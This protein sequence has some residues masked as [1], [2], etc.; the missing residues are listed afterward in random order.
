MPSVYADTSFLQFKKVHCRNCYKCVRNCPVKAIRVINHQAQILE[1]QCILCEKC[2]LVCPQN[3]KEELNMIPRVHDFIQSGGQ[4]IA[5][6]HPAYVAEFGTD[7]LPALTEALKKLGLSDAFDAAAGAYL[8]KTA[9]E[10]LVEERAQVT[11]TISS[12]CPVI[13]QL[14][15]KR[16]PDLVPYLAPVLSVMQAHARYLKEQYPDA[17]ILSVSPCISGLAQMREADNYVDYVITFSELQEWLTA[18]QVQVAA[19]SSAPPD[20]DRDIRLS[21]I[22][23]MSGGF[24]MAMHPSVHQ[25]YLPACGI[26][27]CKQILTEF[28]A[29]PDSYSNCFL[30]LNACPNGCI[31]GPSFRRTKTGLLHG[32]IR[33][34]NASL[35]KGISNYKRDD[36]SAQSLTDVSRHYDTFVLR[37]QEAEASEEDIKKVL[38]QMGKFTPEDELNCGACGYNTCREKAKAV[39]AGKAEISMC[40]PFM[41]ERQESYSNK[42]IN[43]MPGILV[44]ADYQLKVIH[45]NQAARDLFDPLHK[46]E[47]IGAP[48]SDLMDDYS[49]VNLIS[50][51]KNRSDDQIYLEDRKIYLER[52]LAN[53][54]KNQ[55]ILCVMKDITREMEEKLRI[56]KARNNAAAMADKLA[57]EQLKLVHQIASLLG[58]TAADTKVAVEQLKRT[59]LREDEDFDE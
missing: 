11:P 24:T 57:A 14:V 36:F 12:N 33:L 42:I 27:S 6:L 38:A 53:D 29:D 50:F 35:Y 4:V 47:L 15:Q 45:M 25:R 49:L 23:A 52:T 44:T 9:Y 51:D 39:L 28:M 8:V 54:R 5:S 16:Y 20:A 1:D 48:V 2:T 59:I 32:L 31:G 13:V 3:A 7:S 19:P 46:K 37:Q 58:E 41:R 43:V 22:M 34:Q 30:E 55:L 17:R 21:R 26:D 40:V 56:R 18:V 10:N